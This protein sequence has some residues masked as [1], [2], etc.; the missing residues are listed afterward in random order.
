VAPKHP[1]SLLASLLPADFDVVWPPARCASFA[2]LGYFA[3]FRFAVGA[4]RPASIK[5]RMASGRS[6]KSFCLRCQSSS[7]FT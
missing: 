3:G 7:T 5:R 4:A 2:A 6:G 1:N